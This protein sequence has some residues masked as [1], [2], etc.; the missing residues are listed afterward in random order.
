M[1][2]P[3]WSLFVLPGRCRADGRHGEPESL[4]QWHVLDAPFL[5]HTQ[6]WPPVLTWTL[7][8]GATEFDLQQAKLDV[9]LDG[10]RVGAQASATVVLTSRSQ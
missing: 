1:T 10:A 4:G 8:G 3:S 9:H 6:Q 2:T 7:H 5:D